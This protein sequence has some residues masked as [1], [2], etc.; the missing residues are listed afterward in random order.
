M[1]ETERKDDPRRHHLARPP[2]GRGASGPERAPSSRFGEPV[3][4]ER[5]RREDEQRVIGLGDHVPSFLLRPVPKRA[6]HAHE[7]EHVED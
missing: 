2:H 1:A 6:R 3:R 5:P 7:H 4:R